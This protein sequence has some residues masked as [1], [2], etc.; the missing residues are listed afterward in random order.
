MKPDP[1]S[2]AAYNLHTLPSKAS[3]SNRTRTFIGTLTNLNSDLEELKEILATLN[4]P[5]FD[6][7]G[8]CIEANSIWIRIYDKD[9]TLRMSI[10]SSIN[11]NEVKEWLISEWLIQEFNSAPFSLKDDYTER[12]SARIFR[13]IVPAYDTYIRLRY[14]KHL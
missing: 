3:G 14:R 12:F 2:E 10:Q 4:T 13:I 8:S 5:R 9:T 6:F 11:P 7:T 1:L